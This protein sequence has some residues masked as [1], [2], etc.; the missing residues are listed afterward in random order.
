MFSPRRADQAASPRP[1]RSDPTPHE[2]PRPV[3][4]RRRR[5]PHA[6]CPVRTI[7]REE[8]RR[9][10]PRLSRKSAAG[11]RRGRR[12]AIDPGRPGPD[13]HRSAPTASGHCG[14]SRPG[15]TI[16]RARAT[17]R[18]GSARDRHGPDASG[19]AT[20]DRG[21]PRRPPARVCTRAEVDTNVSQGHHPGRR[22]GDAA[23]SDHPRRQQ[24]APA[25]LRQADDLLPAVDADAGR[26]PR[27]PPDLDARRHRRLRA[28][29]G[30]RQPDRDLDHLR[31]AAAP[32]RPGPGLPDR[33]DVR[34]R[35]P[36]GADPR[37]QHLLR[38][39]VP[40]DAP[41]RAAARQTGATVFAYPVKD[42]ERYGVVEFDP[43][44]RVL[45][46]EEK[47]AQPRSHYAVTGLYFYDNQ[48]VEIAARPEA[49]AAGRAGDHR[50]QPR[51]P[52]TAASSASRSSAAGSPGSTPARP[53]R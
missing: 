1:R 53:S 4:R 15:G 39:G 32:R 48:V 43:R 30:R 51:L 9:R 33:R 17:D 31:R 5:R 47:P 41:A 50:R 18:I 35:R 36:R 29:A 34:R 23:L 45:S 40:G 26:H 37:R 46:I 7:I 49:L 16:R 42:P 11:G 20:P 10:P 27:D 14:P 24:A 21:R 19:V 44:G 13:R 3:G 52:A 2:H 22:L 25:G 28:A 38:P 8:P 6:S 12:S